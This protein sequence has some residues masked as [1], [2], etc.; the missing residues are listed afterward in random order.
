MDDPYATVHNMNLL[1]AT[2]SKLRRRIVASG[3]ILLMGC[4]VAAGDLGR[5]FLQQFSTYFPAQMVVGYT[6]VQYRAD[7]IMKRVRGWGRGHCVEAG[8][9]DTN[10]QAASTPEDQQRNIVGDNYEIWDSLPWA[11]EQS[12]HAVRAKN[13]QIDVRDYVPHDI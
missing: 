13:G 9:K 12:T 1:A 6:T 8:V 7:D 2:F 10:Q 4:N 5:L 11:D 3:V